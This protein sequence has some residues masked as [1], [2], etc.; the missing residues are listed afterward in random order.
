MQFPK[1][2][3]LQ[4]RLA[5]SSLATL[6]LLILYL[7]LTNPRFAYAADA[8]SLMRQDHNHPLSIVL[9]PGQDLPWDDDTEKGMYEPD[10]V[11]VNQGI[12]GRQE[13]QNTALANNAPTTPEVNP[14]FGGET[15]NWVF[16]KNAL[17]G[18]LS[19]STPGLPSPV[20]RRSDDEEAEDDGGLDHGLRKRQGQRKL[21]ITINTCGQPTSNV[22]GSTGAPPQLQLFV[23]Q[24]QSLQKPGPGN[25]SPD[26]KQ[27]PI[28]EG[29]GSTTI[30]ADDDVF[31]GVSAPASKSFNGSYSYELAASIDAPFHSYDGSTPFLFLID[32]DTHGAL[33]VTNDTTQANESDPLYQKWMDITPPFSMFANNINDSTIVGL[34]HSYCGLKNSAQITAT[35]RDGEVS[36]GN[37]EVSM[38]DRAI[39]GN[40]KKPKEQFYIK[41]LN[42]SSSYYGFLA[43]EGNSTESGNGVV[44]GG[45]KVWKAMNFTTK[46]G[47]SCPYLPIIIL[48]F[49]LDGNCQVLFNLSFCSEVAYAVPSN[50]NTKNT[51]ELISFYDDNALA[52]YQNFSYS[53]QQIPCNTTST[54]QYSL[55]KNCTDCAAAYKSWLCAVTI[56]RCNDFSSPLPYLQPRNVAQVFIN[57]T[58][59]SSLSKSN[60]SFSPANLTYTAINSSRNVEID[61]YV[62]PG[63][64][65]EVLPCRDLCYELVKSC[66]AALGFAC[67]S[68]DSKSLGNGNESY[69]TLQPG[70]DITCSYFGAAFFLNGGSRLGSSL[71]GGGLVVGLL[72]GL[73]LVL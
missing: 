7:T 71:G 27:V 49:Y 40:E 61:N 57:G 23:S 24:S 35:S 6:I 11:G 3:P 31:I 64:Y 32:S 39:G 36:T 52:L 22:T 13:Q 18:P 58:T 54:A 53:L 20:L 51:T 72:V 45:G 48:I 14:L 12:V 33:L 19:P 55:A 56:P 21:Y 1:L 17:D 62:K 10:F 37:V 25:D 2:T 66:P 59:P 38:T 44:G 26:N 28:V 73:W 30:N 67:P 16:P 9:D 34:R 43:M 46:A 47:Q 68:F 70:G 69:G 4:A 50:P 5:A 29:F 65:K 15:M 60:P 63:P 8:D 42:G 41:S